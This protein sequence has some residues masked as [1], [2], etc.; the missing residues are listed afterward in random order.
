MHF[1]LVDEKGAK[2]AIQKGR[3]VVCNFRLCGR[4]WENFSDFYKNNRYGILTKEVLNNK[5][6]RPTKEEGGGHSV[7]LIGIGEEGEAENK[8]KYLRFLN[9]WGIDWADGGTFKVQSIDVLTKYKK[10]NTGLRPEL[11]DIFFY[12]NELTLEEKDYYFYNIDYFRELF[13]NEMSFAQIKADMNQFYM[14]LHNCDNC[15]ESL[16]L[17]EFKIYRN[18]G[19]YKIACPHC[20]SNNNSEGDLRKFLIL[21]DF[22]ND[23]NKDFDINFEENNYIQI[24]RVSLH[25]NFEKNITNK[26]DICSI[27]KENITGK[28]IDSPFINKVN[29]IICLENENEILKFVACSSQAILVFELIV[30]KKDNKIKKTQFGKNELITID[31]NLRTLCDLKFNLNHSN[32][33]YFAAGGKDLKIFKIYYV[34]NKLTLENIQ[35]RLPDNSNK[36]INKIIFLNDQETMKRMAVCDQYGYIGL[37][38]IANNRDNINILFLFKV[39][40]HSYINCIL[41]LPDENILVSGSDI[42]RNLNFGKLKNQNYIF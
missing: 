38:N 25:E 29:C 9:L 33:K 30:T 12:E 7:L 13:S 16:R 32:I 6:D 14:S 37:Y 3:F 36:N 17:N 26:S 8:K 23:G 5:M 41:Y 28:R 18:N 10:N 31:G 27:G 19:F 39:Q 42:D 4:Q 2:K 40:C 35:L 24:G 1:R 11:Y 15:N 22:M 20:N 21:K 34:N